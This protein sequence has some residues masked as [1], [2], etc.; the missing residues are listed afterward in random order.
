LVADRLH[1]RLGHKPGRVLVLGLTFKENV[2]DLRNSRVIDVIRRLEVLGHE[3]TVHDPLADADEARHEYQA[4]LTEDALERS[5][6]LVV[7]AVPHDAYGLL[8]DSRIAR[9][10]GE[11]GLLA[12]L[13][14]LFARRTLT[15]IERWS[16]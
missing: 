4:E 6:D 8:D 7:V 5:Y 12:D 13:K 14:N 1:E 2:P 16:L 10:V 15:G 3:V 11:G 9:L